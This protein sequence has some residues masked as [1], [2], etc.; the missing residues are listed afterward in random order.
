MARRKYVPAKNTLNLTVHH[1]TKGYKFSR[2]AENGLMSAILNHS[3]FDRVNGEVL[4]PLSNCNGGW[5]S[6]SFGGRNPFD[7]LRPEYR[8]V[9]LSTTGKGIGFETDGENYVLN[10]AFCLP[11]A[12]QGVEITTLEQFVTHFYGK[13]PQADLVVAGYPVDVKGM[14]KLNTPSMFSK[15]PK[16]KALAYADNK[17]IDLG[18]GISAL[19][20]LR[21][22]QL[23]LPQFVCLVNDDGC[24]LLE[25]TSLY[26]H[27]NRL[28]EF[29]GQQGQSAE[30]VVEFLVEKGLDLLRDGHGMRSGVEFIPT[31]YTVKGHGDPS[32]KRHGLSRDTHLANGKAVRKSVRLVIK[33]EK[34]DKSNR[35]KKKGMTQKGMRSLSRCMSKWHTVDEMATALIDGDII[36]SMAEQSQK[37]VTKLMNVRS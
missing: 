9:V 1:G 37:L 22:A 5:L 15:S 16:S 32:S 34:I 2:S 24:F 35:T 12:Y 33:T 20:V 11:N 19:L 7:M 21:Y 31:N 26:W 30:Q 29:K 28:G 10:Q 4:F 25:L 6:K 27:T 13:G 3:S 23:G 17:R 18:V 8:D 36:K 14:G